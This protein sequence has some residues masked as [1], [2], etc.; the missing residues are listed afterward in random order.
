MN[1]YRWKRHIAALGIGLTLSLTAGC[2]VSTEYTPRSTNKAFLSMVDTEPGVSE[3]RVYL[4]GQNLRLSTAIGE[5]ECDRQ[6]THLVATAADQNESSKSLGK[7]GK[8]FGLAGVFVPIL[9]FPAAYFA[10]ASEEGRREAT[11]S[12]VDAIN[13]HNDVHDCTQA[14][15]ANR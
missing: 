7:I 6:A 13:R 15:E 5:M 14:E 9:H 1:L 3:P 12:T 8:A 10:A 2:A 11:A 4:N